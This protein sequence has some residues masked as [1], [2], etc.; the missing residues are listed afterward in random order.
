MIR[1]IKEFVGRLRK[2]LDKKAPV[3]KRVKQIQRKRASQTWY[4]DSVPQE[5]YLFEDVK[6]WKYKDQFEFDK[7]IKQMPPWRDVNPHLVLRDKTRTP[8][9]VLG[10]ERNG[11]ELIIFSIQRVRTQYDEVTNNGAELQRWSGD[12]ETLASKQ[13]QQELGGI[14]PAEFLL[15]EFLLRHRAEILS[16]TKVYFLGRQP[17]NSFTTIENQEIYKPIIERFFKA[18]PAQNDGLNFYFEL[19][20]TKDRVRAILGI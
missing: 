1:R 8:R 10:Y 9:F 18:K 20:P 17:I 7:V 11:Y 5:N 2:R 19:N 3:Q 6:E 16:G 15:C 14:H 12:K 13:L 4:K